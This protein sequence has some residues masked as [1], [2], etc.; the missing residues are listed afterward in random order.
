M[1][2]S[3]PASAENPTKAS[4]EPRLDAEALFRDH[5]LF[6]ARFLHHLGVPAADL[7][8]LV[9]DVFLVAHRKGGYLPGPAQP[10]TWLAAIAVRIERTRWRAHRR[11]EL[12]LS[13]LAVE[14]QRGSAAPDDAVESLAS[15]QMLERALGTLQLE[16]RAAF[17]L[18]ELEGRPCEEIAKVLGV[19]LGTVYSR[20]HTARRRFLSACAALTRQSE[21]PVLLKGRRVLG[22]I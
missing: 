22:E 9:Q 12:R 11:R 1:K 14:A 15:R 20:L 13:A 2:D 7:D 21:D 3:E 8:D 17:V 18:Y 5:A 19:P 10:R 6:V 4:P 16:Q